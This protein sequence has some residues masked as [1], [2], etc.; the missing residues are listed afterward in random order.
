MVSARRF[1]ELAVDHEGKD[2]PEIAPV[3]QAP[4]NLSRPELIA[5]AKED[6]E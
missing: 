1:E 6:A 2:L 3:E 5:S 4:R